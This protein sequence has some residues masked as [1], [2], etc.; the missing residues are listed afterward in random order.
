MTHA[1]IQ[2]L[3]LSVRF[4]SRLLFHIPQLNLAPRDAVY[5]T[6]DN[7]VGNDLIESISGI[8]KTN[9]RQG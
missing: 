2:A 9:D 8:T 4:K 1:S 6:G 7:G 5:L 3:D